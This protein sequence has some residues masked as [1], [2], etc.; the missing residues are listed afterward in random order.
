MARICKR[1]LEAFEA[2]KPNPKHSRD[3]RWLLGSKCCWNC[4]WSCLR[5]RCNNCCRIRRALWWR[6][7]K[8][9]RLR[10]VHQ[11]LVFDDNLWSHSFQYRNSHLWAYGKAIPSPCFKRK[12]TVLGCINNHQLVRFKLY[13]ISMGIDHPRR[14]QAMCRS[15]LEWLRSANKAWLLQRRS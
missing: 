9:C 4:Y 1:N 3:R 13:W 12:K 11:L 14:L 15:N 2:N 5:I 8:W 6:I 10:H 7:G